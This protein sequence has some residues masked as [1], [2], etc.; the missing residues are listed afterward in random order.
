MNGLNR[1]TRESIFFGVNYVIA[2]AWE[3]DKKRQLDFEK[4]LLERGLEFP[5]TR[6]G[7]RNLILVRNSQ[8]PLEVRLASQGP[9]VS[10]IIVRSERPLRSLEVFVKEAEAVCDAYCQTWIKERCQILQCDATIRHLYSCQEYA[11]KYLWEE[12]L[13]QEGKDFHYLGKGPVLGGGLRLVIPATK[14]KPEPTHIE[15]KI[16]SFFQDSRKMFVETHF[17]WPQPR[18]LKGEIK[19]DPEFR[20]KCVEKYAISKVCDFVLKPELEK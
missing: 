14:D 5:E 16:E 17:V 8:S 6:S 19:F 12:R 1:E 4:A 2:I 18:L 10:N 13:G 3:P 7:L 9:Q 15:I 11:F 20:L